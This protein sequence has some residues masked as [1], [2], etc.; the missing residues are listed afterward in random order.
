M[1]RSRS[2]RAP[3]P[4]AL[5]GAVAVVLLAALAPAVAAAAPATRVVDGVPHVLNGAQ[6]A[7]G[8]EHVKLEE[9]WRAGAGESDELFGLISQVLLDAQGNVYLLDTQLSHAV[10]YSPQGKQLRV[11]GREGEGPGEVNRPLD[12]L[13]MPDGSV[14]LVQTFPGKIVKL[15]REGAPAGTFELGGGATQGGFNVIVEAK[16]A[17]GNLVLAGQRITQTATGNSRTFF[18]ASFDGAGAE[19]TRYLEKVVELDLSKPS[20]TE[21]AYSFVYP[22]RW[23]VAPDGR[24]W[25]PA[26]RNRYAINVYAPGGKLE[27][28]VEREY[29]SRPR[30]AEEIDRVNRVLEAQVRGAPM[31]IETGVESTEQDIDQ[32][33]CLAD[34]TVWVLSSRGSVEQ[35]AGVFATWDVFD[36]AGAFVRQVAVHCPGNAKEDGLMPTGDGHYVVVTGLVDAAMAMQGAV[37]KEDSAEAAPME[38]IYYGTAR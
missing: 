21:K 31:K 16:S 22:R 29:A 6:P 19:K 33:R 12:I 4:R 2:G 15:T 5:P 13:F 1:S 14:G 11:I 27:R 20:I 30:T 26:E 17:G 38:V 7:G 9:L 34:G 23:D 18:L 8:V 37:G 25:A 24:V 28:V 36:A 32:L 10:V 35:P 3:F